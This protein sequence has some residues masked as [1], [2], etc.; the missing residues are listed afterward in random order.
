MPFPITPLHGLLFILLL[1]IIILGFYLAN[2]L[3]VIT[4]LR[5]T[6]SDLNRMIH[7]LDHQAKLIIKSDIELKLYQEEVE[8]KLSKLS[9][10]KNLIISSLHMLDKEQLFAQIDEKI[11]NDL[12]FKKCLVL[13]L[14]DLLIKTNIGFNEPEME[15]IKNLL[16]HKKTAFKISFLLTEKSEIC[17]DLL[18]LCGTK[19]FLVAP[20]KARENIH[21]LFLLADH[22]TTSEVKT[23]E[24]EIITII[25]TYLGQ[26]LDNIKL[27]EELYRS[28]EDL[29]TKIKERTAEL[30]KSLRE[31]E[32]V[33]KTKT[34]F[35]SSVSHELRTPLTSVKGFSALLVDEKFGKL[36][37][38]AKERLKKIDENVNKL[39]DM[40]NMLLDIARIESGKMEIKIAPS[41][42]VR[43]IAD[44][45]DFLMPQ[46]QAKE[47]PLLPLSR[48]VLWYIWI[49]ILLTGYS[50]IS[51]TTQ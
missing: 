13:G 17:K 34:D 49:K 6:I 37:P 31:I 1:T 44:V 26:C 40:V 12:G 2:K 8:D 30:V 29:E 39:V 21:A 23:A 27:F 48:K 43:V 11:V 24:K 33:S 38:E 25:C 9:L 36:P 3:R 50:S 5:I 16:F 18:P 4:E 10:L 19:G 22:I 46:M 51:L 47:I 41:D 45:G 20:I 28:K 35:I 32:I 15:T 42:I 14:E 7:A